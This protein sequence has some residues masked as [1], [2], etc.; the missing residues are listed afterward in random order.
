MGQ[1]P[2][3]KDRKSHQSEAKE[4]S[5]PAEKHDQLSRTD[6]AHDRIVGAPAA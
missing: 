3:E 1:A 6:L 4:Q 2:R 5:D